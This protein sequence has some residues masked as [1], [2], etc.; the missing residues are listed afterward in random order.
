MTPEARGTNRL[1]LLQ[2]HLAPGQHLIH[3]LLDGHVGRVEQF[4]VL[5]LPER[6]DATL[7]IAFVSFAQILQ[8]REDVS[9]DSF[10]DQL[11]ITTLGTYLD[12]RRQ[13][14]FGLCIRKDH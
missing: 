4:G 14:N 9:S 12:T 1:P 11:L 13:E 10:F 2:S 8:K 7:T 5:V 3:R 6:R